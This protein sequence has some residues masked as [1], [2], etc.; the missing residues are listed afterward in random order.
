[1]TV[2]PFSSA[3]AQALNSPCKWAVFPG[4]PCCQHH[5]W[6]L[7][8]FSG[9]H[10]CPLWGSPLWYKPPLK[11]AVTITCL[12]SPV[13]R[14]FTAVYFP[15]PCGSR[16]GPQA[17]SHQSAAPN[18]MAGERGTA[19]ALSA[20]AGLSHLSRLMGEHPFPS[21]FWS[22]SH[23][24][25]PAAV[26]LTV[27]LEGST[28]V[29]GGCRCGQCLPIVFREQSQRWSQPSWRKGKRKNQKRKG[30]HKDWG[31]HLMRIRRKWRPVSALENW[32]P[33]WACPMYFLDLR[34][35]VN[36]DNWLLPC[37]SGFK[38]YESKKCIIQYI[39]ALGENLEAMQFISLWGS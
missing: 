5:S 18:S 39:F 34:V 29:G 26:A 28:K 32:P 22:P 11:L 38:E 37:F 7:A 8:H 1:M 2:S 36:S 20:V 24:P 12:Y 35:L 10:P 31:R 27:Y 23:S 3:C 17:L 15:Q 19:L 13:W 16:W 30:E 9:A 21:S 33:A 14:F 6:G 4:S 25:P